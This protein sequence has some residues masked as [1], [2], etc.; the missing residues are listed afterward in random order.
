[1]IAELPSRRI[2]GLSV[3]TKNA[4]EMNFATARIPGLW[5]RFYAEGIAA[6]IENRADPHVTYGVYTNYASDVN[7]EYTLLVGA[8]GSGGEGLT[9]VDVPAQRYRVFESR[10]EMPHAVIQGWQ[11]VWEHFGRGDEQRAYTTDL[12]LY[13]DRDPQRVKLYIAI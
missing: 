9:V 1:M 10:G 7:G 13:D 3:R 2:A 11:Q 5:Q 6:K 4:D 8:E 12:E